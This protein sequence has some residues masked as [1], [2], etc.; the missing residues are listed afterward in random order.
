MFSLS[1]RRA[2]RYIFPAYYLFAACGMVAACY[3]WAWPRR[4]VERW[5]RHHQILTPVLWLVLFCLNVASGPAGVPRV[6]LT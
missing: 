3:L 5:D 4:L 6:D 2:D 1:D